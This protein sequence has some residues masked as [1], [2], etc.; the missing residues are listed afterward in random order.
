M[1]E[2]ENRKT[3]IFA[4]LAGGLMGLFSL[5]AHLEEK[6][7][8]AGVQVLQ[9]ME[10]KVANNKTPG[11]P[12]QAIATE[13]A[14]T[15][16]ENLASTN[17]NAQKLRRAAN[18]FLGYYDMNVRLKPLYCKGVGVD[19]GAFSTEFAR[20]HHNEYAR[21]QALTSPVTP[22][23]SLSL[24]FLSQ[25]MREAAASE[26]INEKSLCEKIASQPSDVADTLKAS[27]VM[28]EVTSLLLP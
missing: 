7:Q 22:N 14:K 15:M 3:W 26:G 6:V 16:R 11:T 23:D 25:A 27:V 9:E 4:L 17:G 28:P 18:M 20:I 8:T 10:N 2:N 13:A 24:R 1:K 5:K 12:T 19:I 21:A